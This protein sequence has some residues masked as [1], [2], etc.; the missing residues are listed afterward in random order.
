MRQPSTVFVVDDDE[1]MRASLSALLGVE[2]IAVETYGSAEAFLAAYDSARPGCLLLDLQMPG[3][4]GLELLDRLAVRG[5]GL[6]TVFLTGHGSVSSS[7]RAMKAGAVDFLEKPLDPPTLLANV[8]AALERDAVA[9]EERERRADVLARLAQLTPREREVMRLMVAGLSC[10]EIAKT[11]AISHRTVEIH[12]SRVFTKL[13]AGSLPE[14]IAKALQSGE[15]NLRPDLTAR[16][17]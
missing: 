13:D 7:V 6:P 5:V 17:A 8:R 10:K 2:G 4:D 9:R 3:M 14:L 11:L 12:R 15:E 1:G 16:G